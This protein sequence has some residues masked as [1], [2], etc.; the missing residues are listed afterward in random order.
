[1]GRT[2]VDA[3]H[4]LESTQPIAVAGGSRAER[5]AED[6][7]IDVEPDADSLVQRDDIDAI[8][9]STPHFCHC[10]EALAAASAGKHVLVEKP[11]ATSVEDCDRMNIEVVPPNV[12]T[13]G[14]DFTVSDGKIHFA[15]S[16]TQ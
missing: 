6:Y 7:G 5:L 15:L 10:D 4:K 12:N 8:V 1:M 2:H 13:S 14:V 11:M 16:A 9:I 3:A